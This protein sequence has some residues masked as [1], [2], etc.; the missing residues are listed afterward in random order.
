MSEPIILAIESSCDDTSAAV[1]KGNTILS[2]IIAS[3]KVHEQYGGVVPELAS[4]AHQQ[5]IV[6]VIATALNNAKVTQKDLTAIAYTRGPGLLGSLLVGSSFAKSMSIALNIPLIEVNH[7]QAH[8]FAH[9]ISDANEQRPNFPFLCL[10]VSGGHTQIVKISSYT[11][12][13]V[14]GETKDDAAGEAFDKIGKV[15]GLPYPAGP[16][17]DRLAQTGNP[18]KFVFTKPKMPGYD[19]SFSGL[20]T[21]VMNFLN[22]EKQK[23]PN[24]VEENLNDLCASVQ[25][26]ITEMCIEKLLQAAQDL[27]IKHIAL[28]GGVSA[29]SELRKKI[30]NLE[31][32]GFTTYIPKFEYTTDNAAMIAMVG[33]IKYQAQSFS[34]VSAKT[35]ARYKL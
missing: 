1:I 24:F 18:E 34:D 4:R 22:K 9:F 25:H 12:L 19:F 29:N 31:K 3:Q 15:L 28:A 11:E 6:P 21:G 32:L 8:I 26:T 35:I 10:T 23:N 17:M 27:N 20:K 30:K 13:E 33:S 14:L 2:N 7:M 16:V 5:N